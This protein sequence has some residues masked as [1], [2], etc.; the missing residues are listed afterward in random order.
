MQFVMLTLLCLASAIQQVDGQ[1]RVILKLNVGYVLKYRSS[2]NLKVDQATL[3]FA[4]QLPAVRE[5]RTVKTVD[6]TNITVNQ[7]N[8]HEQNC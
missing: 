8:K 5:L 1:Q 2:V 6:C 7:S 3:N 4:I